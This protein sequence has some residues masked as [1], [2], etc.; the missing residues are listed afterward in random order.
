MTY[1]LSVCVFIK[2]CFKGGFCLFESMAGLLPLTND[3]IVM[4]L[5]STDGTLEAL[6]TIESKNNKVKV[7]RGEFYHQDASVFADL[8]N[9]LIA[10][11]AHDNVLYYQADEIW[12][13]NLLLRMNQ[14]LLK[15]DFD[16]SFWRI[17][18]RENF[19]IVKWFPH[20]V[21]RVGQKGSFSFVG[22]GMTTDR[23]WDAKICS[24]YDGSYFPKWGNMGQDGIKPFV[25]DM[26]TDISMVGGFLENIPDRRRMHAPFWHEEPTIEGQP[27]NEW[28]GVQRQNGNWFM[29]NTPYNLPKILHYHVGKTK[30]RLRPNLLQALCENTTERLVYGSEKLVC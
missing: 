8:A 12:H 20:L 21:H 30:Y 5:G 28:M 7:I 4:D 29:I 1:P 22:D 18:Y 3:F 15:G 19:Q 17:Q 27:I 16:L 10:Q 9:D 6:K 2:D 25:H 13:E 11:C 14:R 24:Q 23:T 26:I